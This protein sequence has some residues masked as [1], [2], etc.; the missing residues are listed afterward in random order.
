MVATVIAVVTIQRFWKR[1]REKLGPVRQFQLHQNFLE[2]RKT[3]QGYVMKDMDFRFQCDPLNRLYRSFEDFCAAFIQAYWRFSHVKFSQQLHGFMRLPEAVRTTNAA[4]ARLDRDTAFQMV[5]QLAATTGGTGTGG[6]GAGGG[7]TSVTSRAILGQSSGAASHSM[8]MST[9]SM[10]RTSSGGA[11]M[12][13][14]PRG[15]VGVPVTSDIN[16]ASDMVTRAVRGQGLGALSQS[17]HSQQHQFFQNQKQ[18]QPVAAQTATWNMSTRASQ[19]RGAARSQLREAERLRHPSAW[20]HILRGSCF[21]FY[22]NSVR[23]IQRAWSVFLNNNAK[24]VVVHRLLRR[25]QSALAIQRNWRRL[26]SR[27]I[28]QA[29]KHIIHG[30]QNLSKAD[31]YLLLKTVCP[32]EAQILDPSIKARIKFRFGGANGVFPPE[33]YYKVFTHG[34]KFVVS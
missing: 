19:V 13:S 4:L 25:H 21:S 22:H 26:H 17:L 15:G 31:P 32:K 16:V 2:R 34:I 27:R 28:F 30:S 23:A 10:T 12:N 7:A 18:Q 9:T 24:I 6:G 33:I 3:R 29:V 8:G 1:T 14:S 20:V 5:Q 11:M